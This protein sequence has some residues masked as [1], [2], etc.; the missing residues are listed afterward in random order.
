MCIHSLVVDPKLYFVQQ[1][2]PAFQPWQRAQSLRKHHCV[3]KSYFWIIW[4]TFHVGS[5]DRS[6]PD[7]CREVKNSSGPTGA[8]AITLQTSLGVLHKLLAA[9]LDLPAAVFWFQ[10]PY[11]S[12]AHT[13]PSD[14]PVSA[15]WLFEKAMQSLAEH[16]N[17]CTLSVLCA[18]WT[19]ANPKSSRCTWSS[20]NSQTHGKGPATRP[21][22][23]SLFNLLS[24]FSGLTAWV[25][26]PPSA[27]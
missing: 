24:T 19:T 7:E 11:H 1:T 4:E 16:G 17:F 3:K 26:E 27:I 12:L 10:A 8:A 2:S 23:F 21:A 25:A 9:C 14:E 13:F 6:P 5:W 15:L 22:Q 18:G 20:D